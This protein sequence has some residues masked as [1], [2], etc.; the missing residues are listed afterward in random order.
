MD[1]NKRK[2]QLFKWIKSNNEL[3]N[4]KEMGYTTVSKN[5]HVEYIYYSI[6]LTDYSIKL[7]N[8]LNNPN[9]LI[10]DVYFN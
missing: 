1:I 10:K 5:N 3:K 4:I 9:I 2:K 6:A 7:L 8:D